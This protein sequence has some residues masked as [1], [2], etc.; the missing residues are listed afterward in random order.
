MVAHR[1]EQRWIGAFALGAALF[2][3]GC[4]QINLP[5]PTLIVSPTAPPTAATRTA[6]PSVTPTLTPPP[7][8]TP[9]PPVT[10]PPTR[11][12]PPASATPDLAARTP[13]GVVTQAQ[14]F[15]LTISEAQL[16]AA[17]ARRFDAA[18]L[19]DHGSAPRAALGFGFVTLGMRIFAADAPPGTD[20]LPVTLMLQLDH[21]GGLLETVPTQMVP[22][23]AGVTTRQ[24]K[25]GEALLLQALL[26]LI[27]AAAGDGLA[28]VESA[29]IRPEGIAL[30]IVT[31][32]G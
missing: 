21:P 23:H 12:Q 32:G 15:R 30:D 13:F 8:D 17:L 6:I 29:V 24:A 18:P 3:A 28:F 14:G 11:T 10:L 7:S 22:L 5:E 1:R 27:H 4:G 25:P 2:L 9:R 16:N 26:D 31:A 19:P 20:A